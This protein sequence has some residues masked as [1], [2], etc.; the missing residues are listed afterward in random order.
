LKRGNFSTSRRQAFPEEARTPA[1]RQSPVTPSRSLCQPRAGSGLSS[2]AEQQRGWLPKSQL[3]S[4][5]RPAP[6]LPIPRRMRFRATSWFRFPWRPPFGLM[7]RREGRVTVPR[8]QID[9]PDPLKTQDRNLTRCLPSVADFLLEAVRRLRMLA[10]A[11]PHARS[12]REAQNL[13]GAG[14]QAL[15]SWR[16]HS[17]AARE[18]GQACRDSRPATPPVCARKH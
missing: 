11:R 16:P 13:P 18:L 5:N 4:G 10:G 2:P 1:V 12:G 14:P 6:A 15:H 17:D 3:A 7:R 9:A 8:G